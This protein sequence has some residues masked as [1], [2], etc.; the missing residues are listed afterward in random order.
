MLSNGTRV[1]VQCRVAGESVS[2]D[3]DWDYLPKYKGYVSD[4]YISKLGA[5]FPLCSGTGGATLQ[6]SGPSSPASTVSQNDATGIVAE[7]E[8]WIGTHETGTNC[9]PF[10]KALG[11]SCEA[12]CADFAQYVWEQAGMD[13][14]GITA[15]AGSF[16]SYGQQNGTLKPRNATNVAPGDAVVWG[17][18]ASNAQHVGIV[19]Q[20]LANGDVKVING[21]YSD[22]VT[23]TTNARSST[24]EGFGI[25]GFVSPVP[26]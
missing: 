15:Y 7:A 6:P 17:V 24:V 2:G 19:E 21:N 26:N 10:S 9:N 25:A 5:S 3:S 13:T 8:K 14:T 11:R 22:K 1:D 23:E 18:S 16:L 20:V 12:W 4:E